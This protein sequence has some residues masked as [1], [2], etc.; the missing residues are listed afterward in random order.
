MLQKESEQ[1]IQRQTLTNWI[2][3]PHS[4]ATE[5][6]A[7]EGHETKRISDPYIYEIKDGKLLTLNG[8]DI[9]EIMEKKTSLDWREYEAFIKEKNWTNSQEK[10]TIVW[11]CPSFPPKYPVAKAVVSEITPL[12]EGRR[13]LLNRNVVLD[14]GDSD[15]L[16]LANQL[17]QSGKFK[18]K[19]EVRKEPIVLPDYSSEYWQGILE[20]YTDQVKQI[21]TGEDILIK[22]KTL[23][24]SERIINRVSTR[25]G[26][27]VYDIAY[28]E[29]KEEG[30]IGKHQG[31]CS[32]TSKSPF[33][34]FSE[35]GLTQSGEITLECTC[36]F[37]QTRVTAIISEG[38][39]YCPNCGKSASYKC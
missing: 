15:V 31:S 6:L 16:E 37:C 3:N 36:P 30:I 39:I 12:V 17:S 25:Y 35:N 24:Q 7:S 14:I 21:R 26:F 11:V 9:E 5:N 20:N 10:G 1:S 27:V 38:R 32:G 8:E 29:A 33:S 23:K 22:D 13:F 4:Q 18:D 34:V 2:V 19:E 28:K